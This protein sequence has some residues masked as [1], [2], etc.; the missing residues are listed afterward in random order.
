MTL[1]SYEREVSCKDVRLTVIRSPEPIRINMER[2][3]F[4][5][6]VLHLIGN[7]A[8]A[9]EEGGEVR[10]SVFKDNGHAVVEVEDKGPG[11][12]PEDVERIF[13]PFF[14]SKSK[15]LGMG[16]PMVKQVVSEHMGSI[17][18]KPA[19]SGGTVF[20]MGFPLRWAEKH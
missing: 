16:L 14:G 4:K 7:A 15:S 20:R 2:N 9:T 17:G 12:A 8:E 5:R 6:A 19:E 10:P 11:I 3:L 18:V 1:L 13:S